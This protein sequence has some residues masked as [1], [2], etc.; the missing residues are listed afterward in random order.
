MMA[1]LEADRPARKQAWKAIV[2]AKI[3][4]QAGLLDDPFRK[5]LLTLAQNVKSGDSENAEAQAARIYWPSLFP[6]R[7]R[8]GD[9]RDPQSESRFNALLNYGYAIIR[10]ATAR[11]LV[12]AGLQPALGVFHHKRDNP[13]CLADDIMEPLRPLVD[14]TVKAI[15]SNQADEEAL[16]QR[17]RK[18]LL[19][20]LTH[21]V[22][23]DGHSGPLMA[24]LPRY[25]NSFFRLLTR[26]NPG[27]HSPA[28][29]PEWPDQSL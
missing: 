25:I 19:G 21:T 26:E 6:D 10:A 29:T 5:K 20:L 28:F 2:Q 14:I 3:R 16:S 24:T 27:L 8:E 12:S 22:T 4:A 11:A 13:F 18:A 17:D 9:R 15:L 1:Q 23:L 7:Y